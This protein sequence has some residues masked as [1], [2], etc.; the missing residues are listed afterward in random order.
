LRGTGNQQAV[1]PARDAD[2]DVLPNFCGDETLLRVLIFAILFALVVW[3][4]R[5][6]GPEPLIETGLILLFVTWVA[7]STTGLLC[8][9]QRWLRRQRIAWQVILP[10]LA[11]VLNT[12]L[13]HLGA[14]HFALADPAHRLPIVGVAI[15][16]SLIAMHYLYLIAAWKEETQHVAHAREQALRARVRPHFLFNS[17]N[18]IAGLCRSDPAKAEQVTLD[19]ADLFRAA[20]TTG[21]NAPAG[22]RA[23]A[24]ARLSR[25]RA[26]A[27]WRAA[28]GGVGYSGG[29]GRLDIEVPTLV[30]QPL[31]ENAIQH[32]IA[33]S[34]GGGRVWVRARTEGDAVVVTI[35]NTVSDHDR[36]RHAYCGR[37]GQGAAAPCLRRA[38][39]GEAAPRRETFRD[40]HHPA[41][42]GRDERRFAMSLRILIA[43][44]ESPARARLRGLL[45]ELGHEVCAEAVDGLA[46]ERLLRDVHPDAMLLD[47]E[48]PGM[49]G[50]TLARR[51]EAEYPEIPVVLV[52][53]HAEHAVAAFDADVRD[54]VLKPV[55]RERLERA[56]GRLGGARS[57]E[58]PRIRVK[59]GRR[60][61][62]VPLDEIDCFVAEDSYV[63]ARSARIE[64]F[65][66]PAAAGIR[67]D[68]AGRSDSGASTLPGSE[69]SA[70]WHGK[71]AKW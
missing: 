47:I 45:E 41:P 37:R 10:P 65:R 8:L 7:M 48:M 69:I 34:R 2:A 44:D 43:D 53:A 22:G 25:D 14:E 58:V 70:G 29:R 19:L 3:L 30:L 28:A 26:D 12:A 24:R 59:I 39:G 6:P 33:P 52:T 18:T 17:M 60:E 4:L 51:M 49:D 55:R 13:V 71:A 1:P 63:I 5:S 21:P 67:T 38:G 42:A 9:L 40:R 57:K 46:V 54:Y 66:G 64:G 68:I 16:M 32:G 27:V 11:A 61:Q 35:G 36:Q 56:L 20:F 50:L 31:V 15:L 62:L 23:G